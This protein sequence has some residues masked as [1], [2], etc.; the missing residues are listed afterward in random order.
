[1]E[2]LLFILRAAAIVLL[3]VFVYAAK[4][5][6]ISST[7]ASGLSDRENDLASLIILGLG[8]GSIAL[9]ALS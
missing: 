2:I 5:D 4:C 1:M 6:F 3:V 8:C 9:L 7:H